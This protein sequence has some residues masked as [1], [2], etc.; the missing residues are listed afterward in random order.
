[1]KHSKDFRNNSTTTIGKRTAYKV[2][3]V[4]DT[5]LVDNDDN[6]KLI[7]TKSQIDNYEKEKNEYPKFMIDEGKYD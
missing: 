3:K 1:M 7:K 2:F 5:Y 6:Y 4:I